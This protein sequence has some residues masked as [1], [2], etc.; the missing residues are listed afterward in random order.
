[1]A[2][3][4]VPPHTHPPPHL[5]AP[6]ADM[7]LR[8]TCCS[9]AAQSQSPSGAAARCG[10]TQRAWYAPSQPSHSS[11][12]L[13]SRLWPLPHALHAS[14]PGRT[15]VAAPAGGACEAGTT[16]ADAA[17]AAAAAALRPLAFA[18]AG[19]GGWGW[20]QPTACVAGQGSVGGEICVVRGA[21]V[22]VC[23]C[24]CVTPPYPKKCD[25][26]RSCSKEAGRVVYCRRHSHALGGLPPSHY[27]GGSR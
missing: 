13:E 6:A 25:I 21:S 24:V 3:K 12:G 8:C 17:A 1:M 23:V 20:G 14:S 9:Q 26:T 7:L 19:V 18:L 11:R 4:A 22:C 16:A 27:V 15:S 2:C 5:S 10:L